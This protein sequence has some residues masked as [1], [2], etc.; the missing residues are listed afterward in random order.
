MVLTS[1]E[2]TRLAQLLF[3]VAWLLG[4]LA[5]IA[6]LENAEGLLQNLAAMCVFAVACA[7]WWSGCRLSNFGPGGFIVIGLWAFGLLGALL[8]FRYSGAQP[9]FWFFGAALI[10]LIVVMTV[11][12]RRSVKSS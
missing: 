3:L 8:D 4:N 11:S 6:G 10:A 1:R 12:Q 9:F 2:R 7:I 5:G